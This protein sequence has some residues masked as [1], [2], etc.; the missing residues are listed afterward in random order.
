MPSFQKILTGKEVKAIRSYIIA[1][2]QESVT[3]TQ[4]SQRR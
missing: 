2:A 1:R 3:P 4:A